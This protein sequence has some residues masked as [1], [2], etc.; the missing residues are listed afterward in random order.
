MTQRPHWY[1]AMNPAGKVP[2]V[3]FP[4]GSFI[5]ESDII[6]ELVDHLNP[7][8]GATLFPKDPLANAQLKLKA[9]QLS[10]FTP[11]YYGIAFKRA[12]T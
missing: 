7:E 1:Y 5:Y 8:K 11:F 9:R 2:T 10:G 3:E 4:D 6:M 12:D